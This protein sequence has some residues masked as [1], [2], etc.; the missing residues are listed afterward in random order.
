[1]SVKI[2]FMENLVFKHVLNLYGLG[3]AP[4]PSPEIETKTMKGCGLRC[5]TLPMLRM[6]LRHKDSVWRGW[7]GVI[8]AMGM[9]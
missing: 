6:R 9:Y 3:L 8:G 2:C 4:P 5:Y 1:M 7:A